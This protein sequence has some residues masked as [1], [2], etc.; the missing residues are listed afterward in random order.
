[1]DFNPE[2]L[3]T[4]LISVFA[5]VMRLVMVNLELNVVISNTPFQH[6][7]SAAS[8]CSKAFTISPTVCLSNSVFLY[9]TAK[10]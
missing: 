10:P 2:K 4:R 1:M 7:P 5:G 8:S 3:P 6:Y 9:S